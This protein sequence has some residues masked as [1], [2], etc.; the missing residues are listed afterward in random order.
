GGYFVLYPW[1]VTF[2][3]VHSL[4]TC[5]TLSAC[6]EGFDVALL[7]F[8]TFCLPFNW[9]LSPMNFMNNTIFWE[10]MGLMFLLFVFLPQSFLTCLHS[11]L[12]I[13]PFLLLICHHLFRNGSY[14]CEVS[15]NAGSE[16][17][18]TLVS[19]KG[20]CL[21]AFTKNFFCQSNQPNWP[22]CTMMI[23]NIGQRLF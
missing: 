8:Q 19:V 5:S 22:L 1:F 13:P 2:S 11:L 9:N 6:C 3:Q 17:C 4:H 18:S 23:C 12:Y 16:S 21:L 14:T 10:N 7:H 15:N 20:L